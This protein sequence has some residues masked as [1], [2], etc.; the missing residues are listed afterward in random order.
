MGDGTWQPTF[1]NAV[2]YFV[3][4]EYRHWEQFTDPGYKFDACAVFSDSVDP[5]VDAGLAIS[6]EP[7]SRLAPQVMLFPSRGHTP[8]HIAVLVESQGESAVITGDLLHTPC[9][10]A[11]PDWSSTYDTDQDAA[12]VTRRAP[13]TIRRYVDCDHRE[14]F[15]KPV[16]LSC[17]PRRRLFSAAA[18]G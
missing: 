5:I 1:P 7:S 18:G 4:R 16:G 14:P 9:Q 13:R 2:Y 11:R 10:I 17:S 6:I 8:G 12:A 3:D 15:R